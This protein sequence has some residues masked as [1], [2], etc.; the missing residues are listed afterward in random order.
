ME[1]K[2]NNETI[3]LVSGGVSQPKL[4]YI[5]F[6]KIRPFYLNR[7]EVESSTKK[8]KDSM[9]TNGRFR[10]FEVFGKTK[11]GYYDCVDT[12]HLYYA[13]DKLYGPDDKVGVSIVWWVNPNDESAKRKYVQMRN[14]DQV[15]WKLW[16]HVLER[17]KYIGGDY[18]FIHDEFLKYKKVMSIGS[19]IAAYTGYTRN[20]QDCDLKQD[21][22][23]ISSQMKIYGDLMLER[24]KVSIQKIN[25]GALGGGRLRCLLPQFLST[26]LK[27]NN[28]Q[29]FVKF[30][31]RAW[32]DVELYAE[33]GILY[34][35]GAHLKGVYKKLVKKY[36]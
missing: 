10:T 1:I 34:D 21:K 36:L 27:T 35:N 23:T 12:H 31:T 25:K 16:D 24:V 6:G 33:G 13:S 7:E 22:L 3:N 14:Q 26:A 15:T 8:I 20:N 5:P 30:F 29:K 4:D 28:Q 19:V 9:N 11:D 2:F 17:H 18:T 32:E